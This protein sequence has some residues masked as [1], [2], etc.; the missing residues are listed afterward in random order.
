MASVRPYHI[1]RIV[2]FTM[3]TLIG[4]ASLILIFAPGWLLSWAP[5]YVPPPNTS[6]EHLLMAGLG[7]FALAFAYLMCV[8]ARDP[9]R[10]APIVNALVFF[11]VMAAALNLYGLYALGLGAFY[12]PGYLITR[13]IV[14][15]ILAGVLFALRPKATGPL[16][17][18]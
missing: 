14:Q 9:V 4:L 6:Y 18:P 11:L 10:Y 7:I 5:G 8:A 2:L 15:L 13:S 16:P 1:L 17:A 12:P 3:S